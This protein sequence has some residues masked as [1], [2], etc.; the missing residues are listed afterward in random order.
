M[1]FPLFVFY[2]SKSQGILFWESFPTWPHSTKHKNPAPR[3]LVYEGS[4]V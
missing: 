1:L 3:G 4:L 2:S